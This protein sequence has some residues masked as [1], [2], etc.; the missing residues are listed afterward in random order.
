MGGAPE[1]EQSV[2]CTQTRGGAQ[3]S[4]PQRGTRERAQDTW[5][6]ALSPDSDSLSRAPIMHIMSTHWES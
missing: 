4:S 3:T 6:P 5:G 1:A 2:S